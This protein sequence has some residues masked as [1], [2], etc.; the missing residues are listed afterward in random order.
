MIFDLLGTPQ[1]PRGWGQF[2]AAAH[3]IYVSNSDIKFGWSSSNDLGGDS[4]T[5]GQRELNF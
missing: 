3:S 1:G 5:V 4:I 2:F